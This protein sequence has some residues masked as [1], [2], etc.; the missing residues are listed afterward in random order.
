ML[1]EKFE[2]MLRDVKTLMQKAPTSV[3]CTRCVVVCDKSE[4]TSME[5]GHKRVTEMMRVRCR[6]LC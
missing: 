2:L 1:L 6:Q 4:V 5:E 3:L